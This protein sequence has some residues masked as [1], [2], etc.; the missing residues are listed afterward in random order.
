MLPLLPAGGSV[1]KAQPVWSSG[2]V[3]AMPTP[4]PAIE[5]SPAGTATAAAAAVSQNVEIQLLLG[6]RE[7][8]LIRDGKVEGSWPVAI[9]APETPT[10]TG[11]FRVR[12]KVLNPKYQSTASGKVNPTVGP[13]GPLGDRW[14]GFHTTGKDDFGIHGTPW[15][16]WVQQRA[17]VSH[18]C[19]RMLNEH[20][21]RLFD[22][23]E[24]G[25]PVVIKP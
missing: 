9:G 1:V 24:V 18:G 7:I 6:K 13:G 20:V 10:P 2:A 21:R 5:P 17:A 11:T 12:N 22:A 3:P 19:V 4:P 23:V 14:I 25:T 15:P 16:Q 8:S